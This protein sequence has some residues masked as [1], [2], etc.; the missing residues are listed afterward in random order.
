M[1]SGKRF[2][3]SL[4]ISSEAYLNYYQGRART[5][6]VQAEDGRRVQ[7]PADAL[8][9]YVTRAGIQGR[10]ELVTDAGHKL[11]ELRRL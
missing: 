11:I 3:F 4:D 2:R 9:P 8:R 5:V 1:G 7:F 10:F 6:I